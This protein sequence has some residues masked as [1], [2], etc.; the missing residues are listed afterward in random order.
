MRP[1]LLLI[2]LLSL[3]SLLRIK[4]S[5]AEKHIKDVI[6]IK[7]FMLKI[8]SI[9]LIMCLFIFTTMLVIIVFLFGIRKT[10]IGLSYFFKSFH[11]TQF[12]VFIG[13]IFKSHLKFNIQHYYLSI[14]FLYL[15]LISRLAYSQDI[16]KI[17]SF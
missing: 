9:V 2:S 5:L 1:S 12:F 6:S 14:C 4:C 16:V 13:M 7:L 3:S 8:L 17:L 11:G 10:I 15:T